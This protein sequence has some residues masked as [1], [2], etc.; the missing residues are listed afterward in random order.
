MRRA[1][2]YWIAPSVVCWLFSLGLSRG[3]PAPSIHVDPIRGSDRAPGTEAQPL[4]SLSAAIARIAEPLERSVAI[5][6]A[7]G[8]YATTGGMGMPETSLEL[9]R[10]MRPGVEVNFSAPSGPGAKP[11]VLAWRGGRSMVEVSEGRWRFANVQIGSFSKEQRRG[12]EVIG[13]G[14][15]AL[16]NVT[17]RLRSRSDAGILA[18]DGGRVTLRGAIRLNDQLESEAPEESFCGIVA[19]DHGTVEFDTR[20]GASLAIGNG[21]LS[22]SAYGAIRLGCQSARI[23]CFT[24]SNNL[25]INGGGRIDVRNTPVFLRAVDPKNTPIGLEDDGHVLAEEARITIEGENDSAIALQKAS[26]LACT[27]VALK[28]RFGYAV[29]ASSGSTFVGGFVGDV[30][31]LDATTGATLHVEKVVD[32]KIVGPVTASRCGAISLPDGSVVGR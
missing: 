29:W 6:L 13:P 22:V 24:R 17:F 9:S 16:E 25:T 18:R 30:A 12:I 27:E 8:E 28:G 11:A 20:D 7:P 26:V 3:E 31:R 2:G 4:K 1:S 21:S 15:A 23:T 19:R 14:R 10:R 32:G 5:V